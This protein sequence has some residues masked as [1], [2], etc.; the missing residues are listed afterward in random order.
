MTAPSDGGA[1]YEKSPLCLQ[2]NQSQEG[3]EMEM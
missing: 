2:A 3:W 1:S